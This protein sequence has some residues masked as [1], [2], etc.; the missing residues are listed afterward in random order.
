[1]VF[2]YNAILFKVQGNVIVWPPVLTLNVIAVALGVYFVVRG[3]WLS[4]KLVFQDHMYM[5]VKL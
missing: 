4:L 5:E 2:V 1:M 3:G